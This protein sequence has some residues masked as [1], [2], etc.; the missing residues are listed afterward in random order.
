MSLL[1]NS[2]ENVL[3][4]NNINN[5]KLISKLIKVEKYLWHS[6]EDL[7]LE[8]LNKNTKIVLKICDILIKNEAFLAG[9]SV[10][11]A[12]SDFQINDLDIY[13]NRKNV[14]TIY[15]DLMD[16]G[17]YKVDNLCLAPAYDQSFFRKNHIL[18]RI[19]LE[20][21]DF[22]PIDLMIIPDN[23]SL[24]SVVT[25]FDLSFCE[26]W[27]D[28]QNVYAVDPEGIKNKEGV[29]KPDYL[30]SL[31]KYFNDFITKRIKKYTSR[32]F[33]ISYSS[34]KCSFLYKHSEIKT[35][36]NP[37]GTI[38]ISGD[39]GN[40]YIYPEEWVVKL[41]LNKFYKVN[42]KKDF[43]LY[44]HFTLEEF[45]WQ[46]LFSMLKRYYHI[47]PLSYGLFSYIDTTLESIPMPYEYRWINPD[48]PRFP[49]DASPE[50][51]QKRVDIKVKLL[52]KY[53]ILTTLGE[54]FD[55]DIFNIEKS[56]KWS[57]Y[58]NIVLNSDITSDD[59]KIINSENFYVNFQDLQDTALSPSQTKLLTDILYIENILDPTYYRYLL[60]YSEE[61]G[62][63]EENK[64]LEDDKSLSY[65]E[66]KNILDTYF[67]TINQRSSISYYK[68]NY[69]IPNDFE[70]LDIESY[71]DTT[72]DEWLD[73]DPTHLIF[74]YNS[75]KTDAV[76]G[77]KGIGLT[78]NS[79]YQLYAKLIVECK[80]REES[81]KD[82][83]LLYISQDI[84]YIDKIYNVL[85]VG[86]S[87][88]NGI[89]LSK[90]NCV[91]DEVEKKGG[92]RIFYLSEQRVLKTISAL[93]N[94]VFYNSNWN[95]YGSYITVE[96][97]AHCG[98]GQQTYVYDNI[99]IIDK[100]K[101]V[102]RK[103]FDEIV[104][105]GLVPIED[106]PSDTQKYQEISSK[107]SSF[108]QQIITPYT[109]GDLQDAISK[110][111]ILR[112]KEILLYLISTGADVNT[113]NN[114]GY[115]PLM[116]AVLYNKPSIVSLLIKTKDINIDLQ[117][118]NGN[119]AL[120]IASEDGHI[121]IVNSL[122]EATADVN[123]QDI[124]K[125][126][127]LIKASEY[128]Y[129]DI[130]NALIKAGADPY[131][132]NIYEETALDIAE[133]EE[134]ALRIAQRQNQEEEEEEEYNVYTDIIIALQNYINELYANTNDSDSGESYY[135]DGMIISEKMSPRRC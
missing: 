45:T 105:S 61:E 73:E 96:S 129:I 112:S 70:I 98:A 92:N 17:Y 132:K 67:I 101:L 118:M 40:N 15:K 8:T 85:E 7:Y 37:N 93:S 59:E 10:L 18:A 74:L 123:L 32:G 6:N 109:F 76:N 5:S 122:I 89:L 57:E 91:K 43:N 90:L 62:K 125:E 30:E 77:I 107:I 69:L 103:K 25:N 27:F 87:L 75:A 117:D 64:I 86:D 79:L 121:D 60:S 28:G 31:F 22:M 81:K 99:Y 82:E 54:F 39:Y 100:S 24:V 11:S 72:I 104:S 124:N 95:I 83:N 55:F 14:M 116:L 23:I 34:S 12:F 127:A 21:E 110:E 19:R 51:K 97:S 84:V 48:N 52:I 3:K 1:E 88:N 26:I 47:S 36:N 71:V 42:C 50:F 131:L 33:K 114:K 128:G 58:I 2:L 63:E 108:I 135:Y 65:K 130:V 94:V 53:L 120:M 9:G 56:R 134:T 16:T 111:D 106:A 29:L 4:N 126:T 133:R 20:N 78:K 35:I 68:N 113:K 49:E 115:T 66:Y 46:N 102:N 41:V 38:R 44:Y 119:T 80:E 13:V